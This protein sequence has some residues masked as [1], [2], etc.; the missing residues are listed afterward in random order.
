[1]DENK[2]LT[3]EEI[4]EGVK[5]SKTEKAVKFTPEEEEYAKK[6]FE[7]LKLPIQLKDKDLEFGA[8]EL[9]IRKLSTKN[10]MQLFF[11][12]QVANNLYLNDI[13][14]AILDL[15]RLFMAFLYKYGVDDITKE[16]AATLEKLQDEASKITK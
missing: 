1:M 2:T 14:R 10:I 5:K 11:R 15:T 16:I 9:D 6:V 13:S 7:E 3:P 12:T 8:G 4:A